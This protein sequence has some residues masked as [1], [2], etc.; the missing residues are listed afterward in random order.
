MINIFTICYLYDE[1]ILMIDIDML[2]SLEV[3]ILVDVNQKHF[4]GNRSRAMK[5][6]AD[7]FM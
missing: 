5:K 4:G 7:F 3:V 6:N 1:E 2:W